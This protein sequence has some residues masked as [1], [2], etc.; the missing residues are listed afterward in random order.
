[1]GLSARDLLILGAGGLAREV[2][3][4]ARQIDPHRDRWSAIHFVSH[5][6][7]ELG[8]DL[9]YGSVRYLDSD[10]KS[11]QSPVDVV[12][13]IGYPEVK[14]RVLNGIAGNSKLEF[15]NLIHP[16]VEIDP[17]VVKIGMGNVITK[18]VIATCGVRIGDFNLFN[19]N[20]TVGHDVV[21]GNYNVLNP[22]VAASGRVTIGDEC[23][24]GTGARVLEGLEICSNAIVGAGAVVTRSIQEPGTYIGVPAKRRG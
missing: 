3:Q 6:A 19:W 17:A 7:K 8:F 2:A 1:M 10:L 5:D 22:A 21:I 13:G 18:G 9:H 24:L 12:V 20:A 16:S 11:V 4:L 14:R 15:P 23:L